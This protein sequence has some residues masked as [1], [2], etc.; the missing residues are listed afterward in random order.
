M[1]AMTGWFGP[2]RELFEPAT[3]YPYFSAASLN[4]STGKAP[5]ADGSKQ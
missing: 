4:R 5:R 1:E 3:M 2:L